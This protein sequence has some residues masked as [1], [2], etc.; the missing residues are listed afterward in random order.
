MLGIGITNVSL[1]ACPFRLWI[2]NFKVKHM[3]PFRKREPQIVHSREPSSNVASS[4][5]DMVEGRRKFK[6]HLEVISDGCAQTVG[7][8]INK[9]IPIWER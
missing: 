7:D 8:M 3:V 1:Q 5:V 6:W 2:R 4:S 9:E